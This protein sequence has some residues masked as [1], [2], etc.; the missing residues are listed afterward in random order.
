M[1]NIPA[2]RHGNRCSYF[3]TAALVDSRSTLLT[4]HIAALAAAVREVQRRHRFRVSAY[5]VLPDHLH[6]ICSSSQD[7]V[8]LATPCGAIEAAFVQ[9]VARDAQDAS[10]GVWRLHWDCTREP[11]EGLQDLVDHIHTDPVR[12]GL[13]M[14]AAFWPWSSFSRS[15]HA[16]GDLARGR[17]VSEGGRVQCLP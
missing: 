1:V 9:R 15:V 7:E 16:G 10:A 5:V 8:E 3:I 12:H 6:A 2:T 14:R 11:A 4:R 17:T 13:A